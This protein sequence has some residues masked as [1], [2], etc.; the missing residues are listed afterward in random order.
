MPE[1]LKGEDGS[2]DAPIKI[3]EIK[4]KTEQKPMETAKPA[5]KPDA[6]KKPITTEMEKPKIE[7]KL[8]EA[9]K[10]AV[11]KPDAAKKKIE[12]KYVS[13]MPELTKVKEKTIPLSKIDEKIETILAKNDESEPK[14]ETK[15]S[16]VNTRPAVKSEAAKKVKDV[17]LKKHAKDVSNELKA[18]KGKTDE[19]SKEA[20]AINVTQPKEPK[21][22]EKVKGAPEKTI[23]SKTKLDATT[24]DIVTKPDADK[25][26]VDEKTKESPIPAPGTDV[27]SKPKID[28]KKKDVAPNSE[29][30]I[31][32]KLKEGVSKDLPQKVN[33]SEPK[34]EEKPI[35]IDAAQPTVLSKLA[36]DKEK[37]ENTSTSVER[38]PKGDEKSIASKPLVQS[39]EK[40]KQNPIKKAEEKPKSDVKISPVD[41]TTKSVPQL[42]KA[43][44][45]KG[46]SSKSAIKVDEKKP[47]MDEKE[48]MLSK[49]PL[50]PEGEREIKA[51]ISTESD[52]TR[53]T[54][55][56]MA[57]VEASR[58]TVEPSTEKPKYGKKMKSETKAK[59]EEKPNKA[60]QT[61]DKADE[62]DIHTIVCNI[63]SGVDRLFATYF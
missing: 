54:A 10:G 29:K 27:A 8:K 26:K 41:I 31:E 62:E 37:S 35:E 19:K 60:P 61:A 6:D 36:K 39:E 38:K 40:P 45:E 14:V 24:L 22:D 1:F 63:M 51:T 46:I 34:V 48:K 56:Q 58:P 20:T 59:S 18:E 2:K 55:E 52:E 28:E 3:N 30:K 33:E 44:E 7:Q 21:M 16:D 43:Q 53:P 4:P 5:T 47:K 50:I 42:E 57:S 12:P 17:K 15:A 9:F 23:E 11:D 13:P 32:D 25:K 49:L